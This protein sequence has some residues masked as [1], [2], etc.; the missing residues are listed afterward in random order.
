MNELSDKRVTKTRAVPASRK[1]TATTLNCCKRLR[2]RKANLSYLRLL[3]AESLP[4]QWG[5]RLWRKSVVL[6]GHNWRTWGGGRASAKNSE[7]TNHL[8]NDRRKAKARPAKLYP[9]QQCNH[10][11][12]VTAKEIRSTQLRKG[13]KVEKKI[14]SLSCERHQP[15]TATVDLLSA[16]ASPFERCR[17]HPVEPSRRRVEEERVREAGWFESDFPS[18]RSGWMQARPVEEERLGGGWVQ[19]AVEGHCPAAPQVW[20]TTSITEKP[21]R[22]VCDRCEC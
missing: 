10:D 13:K 21:E 22:T 19:G 1:A 12:R 4:L 2:L 20:N 11:R 14:S 5:V 8:E 17:V 3:P 15:A 16:P 7:F 18:T 6:P 9:K